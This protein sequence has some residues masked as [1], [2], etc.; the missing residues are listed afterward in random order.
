MGKYSRARRPQQASLCRGPPWTTL[1]ALMVRATKADVWMLTKQV[2]TVCAVRRKIACRTFHSET[3][4]ARSASMNARL[5]K[6]SSMNSRLARTCNK[7]Y[8]KASNIP[9]MYAKARRLKTVACLN[10][11][12]ESSR[13][14]KRLLTVGKTPCAQAAQDQ[15]NPM[16][17]KNHWDRVTHSSKKLYVMA[18][19][20]KGRNVGPTMMSKWFARNETMPQRAPTAAIAMDNPLPGDSTPCHVHQTMVQSDKTVSSTVHTKYKVARHDGHDT[21]PDAYITMLGN[22]SPKPIALIEF[23]RSTMGVRQGSPDSREGNLFMSLSSCDT[24]TACMVD[25]RDRAGCRPMVRDTV[26]PIRRNRSPVL[27]QSSINPK[28]AVGVEDADTDPEPFGES[29]SLAHRLLLRDP[30]CHSVPSRGCTFIVWPASRLAVPQ[31]AYLS[32]P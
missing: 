26:F 1:T 14:S 10:D 20:S 6:A 24:R 4:C 8:I 21:T 27:S 22:K 5:Q 19:F 7:Q 12:S 17:A 32:P 18:Y 29:S 3:R 31:R 23:I 25:V 13:Q 9:L 15:A 11:T 30:S 16:A 2:S 28:D